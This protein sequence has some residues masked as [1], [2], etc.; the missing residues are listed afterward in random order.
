MI[1]PICQFNY[2]DIVYC[3]GCHQYDFS[4]QCVVDAADFKDQY[5]EL[6][7]HV[8]AADELRVMGGLAR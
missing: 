2:R 7:K 4:F 5:R 3:H 6:R 8:M 1:P